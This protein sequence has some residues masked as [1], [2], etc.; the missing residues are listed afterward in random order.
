MAHVARRNRVATAGPT[1]HTI[2]A[3]AGRTARA[4]LWGVAR[5]VSLITT[6][7]VL[8]I[9]AGILLVVLDANTGNSIVNAI[10]DAGR[11]LTQPFDG[12]FRPDGHKAEIAANW[13]LAAACYAL[14][15]GLIVRL[16]RR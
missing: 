12:F 6:A 4:G 3:R 8:L 9:L 7:V 14:A 13:G 2:G 10:L 11:W 5:I 1:S 15:G 16:L